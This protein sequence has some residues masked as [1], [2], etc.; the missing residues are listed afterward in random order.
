[1]RKLVK[2]QLINGKTPPEIEDGGYFYNEPYIYGISMHL[3]E[4]YIPKGMEWMSLLEMEALITN[5]N[6][7]AK[8]YPPI[9]TMEPLTRERFEANH[10]SF[11]YRDTT[12]KDRIDILED[13]IAE[14]I[15]G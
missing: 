3:E 1:M 8:E 13:L 11:S 10:V 12:Q 2:Y 7:N 4:S 14:L 5:I 15:E 9:E 6:N